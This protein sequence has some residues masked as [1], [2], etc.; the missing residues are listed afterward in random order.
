LLFEENNSG[1]IY[2]LN[3]I[4]RLQLGQGKK[5]QGGDKEGAGEFVLGT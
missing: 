2:F 5:G 3:N 4:L 1:I